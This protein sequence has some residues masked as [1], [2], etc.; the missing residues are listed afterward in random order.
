MAVKRVK[1]NRPFAKEAELSDRII[2]LIHEYDNEL[3]L[4]SV[5]GILDV[6]KDEIKDDS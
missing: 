3:S 1:E 6:V 5:I 2:S 4:V